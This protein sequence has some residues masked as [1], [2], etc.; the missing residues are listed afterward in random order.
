MKGR[1]L[2]GRCN[3]DSDSPKRSRDVTV[4]GRGSADETVVVVKRVAVDEQGD[5]FRG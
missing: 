2:P 5:L 4:T 1:L 3:Y